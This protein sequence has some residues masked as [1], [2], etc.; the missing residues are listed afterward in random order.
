MREAAAAAAA[1]TAAVEARAHALARGG[2]GDGSERRWGGS[3]GA[4]EQREEAAEAEDHPLTFGGLG[5]GGIGGGEDSRF[6]PTTEAT[7]SYR[8]SCLRRLRRSSSTRWCQHRA[9]G[10]RRTAAASGGREHA[11]ICLPARVSYFPAKPPQ[12]SIHARFRPAGF[13]SVLDA[14]ALTDRGN[15]LGFIDGHRDSLQSG[16]RSPTYGVRALA[17]VGPPP[18]YV[19]I[20]SVSATHVAPR[21]PGRRSGTESAGQLRHPVAAHAVA[22]PGL[23]L[24][25]R[26]AMASRRQRLYWRRRGAVGGGR[27]GGAA[28]P[29]RTFSGPS[30]CT[31]PR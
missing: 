11:A 10:T 16:S 25:G 2:G 15:L 13:Y 20:S 7:A 24:R 30:R 22:N 18:C 9:F 12:S 19:A 21:C 3:G 8:P 4:A 14:G 6:R 17:E 23:H 1:A 31:S 28:R 5:G 26:P 29:A 27:G